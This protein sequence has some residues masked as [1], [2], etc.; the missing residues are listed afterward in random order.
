VAADLL[1]DARRR[2][3]GQVAHLPLQRRPRGVRALACADGGRCRRAACGAGLVARTD[4]RRAVVVVGREA[5]CLRQ[6]RPDG[7]WCAAPVL[8]GCP[9]ARRSTSSRAASR[10]S[11]RLQR[12]SLARCTELHLHPA[13]AAARVAPPSRR[14]PIRPRG[15]LCRLSRASEQQA[16]LGRV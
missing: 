11:P 15:M 12:A 4:L 3:H 13:P 5:G 16:V 2:V 6:L 9:T 7:C 10:G 14:S 8:R 1:L